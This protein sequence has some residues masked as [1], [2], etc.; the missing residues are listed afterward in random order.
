MAKQHFDD[1]NQIDYAKFIILILLVFF[2]G[3]NIGDMHA[4]KHCLNYCTYVFKKVYYC[5][6]YNCNGNTFVC[7]GSFFNTKI[8]IKF[9]F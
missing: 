2:L 7:K 5:S 8:S 6:C 9:I 1:E 4:K 3:L